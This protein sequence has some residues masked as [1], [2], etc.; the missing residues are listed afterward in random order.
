MTLLRLL[1]IAVVLSFV[2]PWVSCPGYEATGFELL[3][4]DGQLAAMPGL[5]VVLAAAFLALAVSFSLFGPPQRLH[6][7]GV[8]MAAAA[9]LLM[10]L[11]YA[12]RIGRGEQPGL[13]GRAPADAVDI[14]PGGWLA[15][16]GTL[17][18]GAAAGW[19]QA[20]SRKGSQGGGSNG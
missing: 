9:S 1:A 14:E 4:G 16:L 10:M 19:L 7:L 8:L 15:F 18:V 13:L 5:W 3:R 12:L 6:W 17:G 2:L 11:H 20:R